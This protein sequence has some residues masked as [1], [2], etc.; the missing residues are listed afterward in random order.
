MPRR[1]LGILLLLLVSVA[2]RAQGEVLFLRIGERAISKAEFEHYLHHS[3]TGSPD[4]C[5]QD[6][7]DWKI[8]AIH[9]K[10]LQLDTFPDIRMR[11][12][13][14]QQRLDETFKNNGWASVMQRGEGLKLTSLTEPLSQH[15]SQVE[16]AEVKQRF[17][18][19]YT[20]LCEAESVEILLQ[21]DTLLKVRE[22]EW[23]PVA[24]LLNEWQEVLKNLPQ[25]EWSK[26]FFSPEGIHVIKWTERRGGASQSKQT[27]EDRTLVWNEIQDELLV[28]ALRGSAY[29]VSSL[30]TED[31]L[32]VYFNR[33]R[34]D[35]KWELPH[36]RGAVIHGKDPKEVKRVR[37]ALKKL[38]FASWKDVL[39]SLNEQRK[40]ELYV[41]YGIFPIGRNAYVDKLVFKCGEFEPMPQMP[42]VQTLG[43]KLKKGPESYLDVKEEVKKDCSEAKHR[44]WMARLKQKYNVE[45]NEDVLK[46][47]NNDGTK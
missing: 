41:E 5:L 47:V 20:T 21:T 28:D 39:P 2:G 4:E 26:P 14:F 33:H 38:P 6:F 22:D 16:I 35:Y 40:G 30:C 43:K 9:A 29:G 18:S 17:E 27:G 42:L 23:V 45:M 11:M 46:T 44:E 7:I 13:H 1:L 32:E 10:E 19:L 8:K 3:E 15:A 36:F 25:G 31:E 24:A 37:K 34:M 12:M